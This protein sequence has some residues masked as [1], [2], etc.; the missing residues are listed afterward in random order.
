MQQK[1]TS[2]VIVPAAATVAGA[3]F[4]NE[5]IWAAQIVGGVVIVLGL[6]WIGTERI[7]PPGK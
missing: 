4:F 6:V 7:T 2:S 5:P 3:L 1:R